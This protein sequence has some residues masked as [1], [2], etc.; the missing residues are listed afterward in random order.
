[1]SFCVLVLW[2]WLNRAA[3]APG[4]RDPLR[5]DLQCGL[6]MHRLHFSNNG[7]SERARKHV[8]GTLT[9]AVNNLFTWWWIAELSRVPRKGF[10]LSAGFCF[11]VIQYNNQCPCIRHEILLLASWTLF[12]QKF[13]VFA[14]LEK[15]INLLLKC[16][17]Q[18]SFSIKCYTKIKCFVVVF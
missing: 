16:S 10:T 5:Y 3:L 1:M 2:I 14:N 7:S 18:F 6:C 17:F 8:S 12:N 11:P 9:P 13:F 4:Q 15:K